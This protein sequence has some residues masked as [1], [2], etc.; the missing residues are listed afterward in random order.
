VADER[1]LVPFVWRRWLGLMRSLAAAVCLWRLVA[2]D[3]PPAA[4][5]AAVAC[6]LAE[7][8][9]AVHFWRWLERAGWPNMA[10][11]AL[12]L[13]VF[14]LCA[15]LKGPGAFWVAA[16]AAVILF[17]SAATLDDAREVLL[18]TVLALSFT[19][20]IAPAPGHRLPPLLVALGLFGAVCSTQRA[21]LWRRLARLQQEVAAARARGEAMRLEERQRFAAD[22]HDGPLQALTGIQM[23][24][25]ALRRAVGRDPSG[26]TEE[27]AGLEESA[28]R[29]ARE[30]RAF[31]RQLRPAENAGLGLASALRGLVL[32]FQNDTGIAATFH[33]ESGPRGDGIAPPVE[34]LQLLREA[35]HNVQKHSRASH[36]EVSLRLE[37]PSR[38]V[39][40]IRD[41]G[42]GFPFSGA[43]TLD[44]LEALRLG[45]A[46]IKRR[47]RELKAELRLESS[48]G[49]GTAIEVRVPL[50]PPAGP[51]PGLPSE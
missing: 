18:V 19:T 9:L 41:D 6:I 36:V 17:L 15:T 29:Q 35:L 8:G 28:A 45:P 51:P 7:H 38:A 12:D 5:L 24:L 47:A 21:A 4:A 31:V 48:P 49:A 27:L 44:E 2:E 37:G 32:V 10:G 25:E 23:R 33:D 50:P 42:T 46:S 3:G 30:L 13:A 43:Y 16:M 22:L 26:W 11:M 34:L 20:G 1:I 40:T 39:L 14:G